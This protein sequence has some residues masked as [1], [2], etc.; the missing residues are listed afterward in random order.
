[1]KD[2]YDI[3]KEK[4]DD[5][6]CDEAN[7]K[8]TT[9]PKPTLDER[10]F[11]EF[12]LNLSS[13]GRGFSEKKPD[14]WLLNN[15]VHVIEYAAIAEMQAQ[16]YQER[17]KTQTKINQIEQMEMEDKNLTKRLAEMQ[18]EIERLVS[19][20]NNKQEIYENAVTNINALEAE[21]KKLRSV[22]KIFRKAVE[23]K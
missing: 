19:D 22:L 20:I 9:T 6:R 16:N 4:M 18:A 5:K 11:R 12:W 21:N 10:K 1:M 15:A 8:L 14:D 7:R 17:C 13:D 2:E 23:G 3:Y